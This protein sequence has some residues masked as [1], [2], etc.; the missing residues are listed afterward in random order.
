M[1]TKNSRESVTLSF[2]FSHINFIPKKGWTLFAGY[3]R[4]WTMRGKRRRRPGGLPL[5]FLPLCNFFFSPPL[6]KNS[7]GEQRGVRKLTI[8]KIIPVHSQRDSN[9]YRWLNFRFIIFL[10]LLMLHILWGRY[11]LSAALTRRCRRLHSSL[12]NPCGDP[13]L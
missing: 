4:A 1:R 3:C 10:F 8:S 2:E 6:T 5:C 7:S 13:H 12:L 9:L 11:R